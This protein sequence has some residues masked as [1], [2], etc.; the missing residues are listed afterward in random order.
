VNLELRPIVPAEMP[1]YLR[2]DE[3]G[4]GFRHTQDES[5]VGWAEAEIDRSVAVFD[6]DD[7]VGTG[8]NYSLELTLPGG[9]II[10]VSGVS[11][12][13]VRPTHRRRGILRRMMTYLVEEGARRDE[14]ASI[15]TAS[16]GG[17]YG[18]FGFGVASRVLAVELER[19]RMEFTAPV[20]RGRVRLIEP[21]EALKIAPALFERVRSHR[22]GAVSRP[23]VWW[24]GE[25]APKDMVKHRFDVV[26]EIDGQVE[27]YVV[28]G[29]DGPWNH[30]ISDKTVGVQ[31][32]VATS[33]EA[34]SALW[35]YLCSIDLTNRV[36]HWMVPPDTDLP[37]RLRDGRQVRTTSL[38]DWL[39]LRP[40]DVPA[41]L[42][43][44]RYATAERLVLEVRDGMRPDG[45][46]AGRFRLEGGPDGAACGRTEAAA[47]L[48]LDVSAL[49][50]I[51]LGG[52]AASVLAR[53][54][55]I[56]EHTPGTL[57]VVDRMF[58]ADRAPFAF[59]WF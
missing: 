15:L 55:G 22:N 24:D 38:R 6:G 28:Y 5:R 53:A 10:P 14:S 59:T 9:A 27:G 8:R 29:V 41:L 3:Y 17:I 48:T 40:V 44:R 11:W 37:W 43:A 32:L 39:W 16:E 25:W 34:E 20:T 50:A 31:D 26:Y 21:D 35:E 12:I 51:S 36:T 30:G 42:G 4:F 58:S 18:R 52:V 19:S 7:I 2:T 1:G 13:S 45:D 56:E 47:D 54:G 23:A 57:G 46:A 49:G 33:P